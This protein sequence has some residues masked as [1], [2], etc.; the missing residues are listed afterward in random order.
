MHKRDSHVKTPAETLG[1]T[2]TPHASSEMVRFVSDNNPIQAQ[3][4]ESLHVRS[5]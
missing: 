3:R 1:Q 4:N 5:I 2:E